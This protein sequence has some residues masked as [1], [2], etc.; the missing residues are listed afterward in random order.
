MTPFKT[1]L[2]IYLLCFVLTPKIN[3]SCF[4]QFIVFIYVRLICHRR[5]FQELGVNCTMR[6][7]TL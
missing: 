6:V 4:K 1:T 7:L 3:Q 2:A 5:I